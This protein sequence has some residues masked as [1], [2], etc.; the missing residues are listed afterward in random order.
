[1]LSCL[2]KLLILLWRKKRGSTTCW[3][4]STSLITN[5]V[6]EAAQYII[7]LNSSSFCM[8]QAIPWEFRKFWEWNQPPNRFRAIRSHEKTLTVFKYYNTALT[9][10]INILTKVTDVQRRELW[11]C[12][13]VQN[14]LWQQRKDC[15]GL[16]V[17]RGWF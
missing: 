2:I 11:D 3:N 12:Q 4:L 7:L 15:F 5:S 9:N 17:R 10:S 16:L 6:P 14:D 1:M 13:E 8:R